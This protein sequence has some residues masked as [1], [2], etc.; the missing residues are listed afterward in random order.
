MATNFRQFDAPKNN[1]SS[2]VTYQASSFL[3]QGATTGVAS[4][5]LH[6][7]LFYQLSTMMTALAQM[8]E[9]KGYDPQDT[10]LATLVTE[11]S[12]IMTEAD[13]TPYALTSSLSGYVAK[14]T[15]A[16]KTSDYVILSTDFYNV[17]EANKATAIGFTL[18]VV[19]TIAAGAWVKIKNIGAGEL[20]ITGTVDGTVNPALAQWEEITI[21]SDGTAWRG[22]VISSLASTDFDSSLTANGY[23]KLPSG[24]IIQWGTYDSGSDDGCT[25][26][27]QY[28]VSFA[29]P[30]QYA[31]LN[32]MGSGINTSAAP[33]WHSGYMQIVSTTLVS[34]IIYM[35]TDYVDPA[36]S[37]GIRGYYWQA[38]GY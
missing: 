3:S 18:P 13:M 14:A 15:P 10:S 19:G 33:A 2:D 12:H 8:M 27:T 7:K 23:Q 1:M 28:P 25:F 4:S 30:F 16:I 20:T 31:C 35:C 29:T 6:N 38:I 5:S 34:A 32:M 36:F 9:A 21:Y 37:K 11:L 22:K 26:D 24:L 17:L